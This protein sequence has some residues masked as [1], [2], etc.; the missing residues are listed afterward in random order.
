MDT[1]S[2]MKLADFKTACEHYVRCVE[3]QSHTGP[4]TS[5]SFCLMN[6]KIAYARTPLTAINKQPK[7][8]S[9]ILDG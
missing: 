1:E 7:I 3:P 5:V 2:S 4:A 8:Y 6:P 9:K